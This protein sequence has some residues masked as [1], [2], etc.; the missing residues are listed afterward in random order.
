M[1]K[2]TKKVAK[3]S[4]KKAAP[5]TTAKPFQSNGSLKLNPIKGKT[6]CE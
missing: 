6:R 5:M 3:P 4:T 2:A 1:A